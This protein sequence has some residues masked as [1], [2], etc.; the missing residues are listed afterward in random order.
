MNP[1]QYYSLQIKETEDLIRDAHHLPEYEVELKE[2]ARRVLIHM[3]GCHNL[4]QEFQ[5]LLDEANQLKGKQR[6]NETKEQFGERVGRVGQLMGKIIEMD[7][8]IRP[9]KEATSKAVADLNKYTKKMLDEV[10]G[11]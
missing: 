1:V 9:Q 6:D 7:A 4:Y 11:V 5:E 2:Y 3:K 10:S 8:K